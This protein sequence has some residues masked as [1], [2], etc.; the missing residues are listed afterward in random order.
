[1]KKRSFLMAAIIWA[2]A[3]LATPQTGNA[4]LMEMSDAD[5]NEITGQAG[6]S[7]QAGEMIGLHIE[8]EAFTWANP[9]SVGPDGLPAALTF[10]DTTLNGWISS[11]N[12]MNIDFITEQT[13]AGNNVTAL[14]IN[15][16]DMT[17]A[18]DDFKTNIKL[19]DSSLGVFGIQGLRAQI[20]GN[21]RIY[22]RSDM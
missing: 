4:K 21:V 7:I 1:M 9:D 12:G 17:V 18:I 3:L 16:Q 19:G 13:A 14:S 6:F 20:S 15:M 11:P 10:A 22:T 5:L 8:S 2:F